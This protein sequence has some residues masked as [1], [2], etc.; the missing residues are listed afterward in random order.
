MHLNRG[1]TALLLDVPDLSDAVD[2]RAHDL[3]TCIE[4]GALHKTLHV[5]LQHTDTRSLTGEIPDAHCFV[6]TC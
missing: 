5:A 6:A 3:Q 1:N 2:S 4:P